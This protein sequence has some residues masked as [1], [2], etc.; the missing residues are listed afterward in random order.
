MIE[1]L[2]VLAAVLQTLFRTEAD[3]LAREVQLV[4]RSRKLTGS[5][6]AQTLVFGWLERPDAT[7]EQLADFALAAGVDVSPQAIDQRITPATVEFLERLLCRALEYGCHNSGDDLPLLRRFNGVYALD[8][9]DRTLPATLADTY[10]GLGGSTPESGRAGCG[11]QICLELSSQGI[12]DVQRAGIR[13]ADLR[14]DLAHT[15]LPPGSL[16]LADL[17]FFNLDLLAAYHTEGVYYVSRWKPHM[18]LRDPEGRDLEPIE[19]LERSGRDVVDVWVTVGEKRLPT[20]LVAFRLSPEVAARRRQRLTARKRDKGKKVG[21]AVLALCDWDVTITNVPVELLSAEE[22]VRLRRLRWQ[23]EL[24]FKQFKSVGRLDEGPGER[25]ERV[26]S[27]LLAKLL[28]QV[29]QGWQ[30]LLGVGSVLRWSWYRCSRRLQGWWRSLVGEL[31]SGGVLG[32][33]LEV[34]ASRLRRFG[35]KKR[36][37]RRPA[38]FQLVQQPADLNPWECQR[39]P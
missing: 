12:I 29:V 28:G 4:R 38:A 33:R 23:V 31:V 36:Q 11:I 17:G 25:P 37:K 35:K 8:T 6:L 27:E 19:Y 30:L 5:V 39:N 24:L 3:E 26:E 7:L 9:T 21:V 34:L 15:G 1:H 18:R 16:R 14:F 22:V 13:T 2:T 32:T 10:P 20:R